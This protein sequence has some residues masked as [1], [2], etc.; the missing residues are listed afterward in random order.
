M[1]LF[2]FPLLVVLLLYVYVQHCLWVYSI[3]VVYFFHIQ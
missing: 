3:V 2:I 1:D